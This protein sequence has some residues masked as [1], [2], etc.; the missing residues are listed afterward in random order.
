MASLQFAALAIAIAGGLGCMALAT[1]SRK[2][3]GFLPAAVWLAGFYA[4]PLLVVRVLAGSSGKDFLLTIAPIVVQFAGAALGIWVFN[5]GRMDK[6]TRAADPPPASEPPAG[7]FNPSSSS[8][9]PP[10]ARPAAI[11]LCDGDGEW[12]CG[13]CGETV[14]ENA[15]FCGACGVEL[16]RLES[17]APREPTT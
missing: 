4:V 13:S 11:A 17:K 8:A 14:R 5:L 12:H 3:L 10:P 1:D 9:T 7:R 6:V 2:F 16:R 15:A